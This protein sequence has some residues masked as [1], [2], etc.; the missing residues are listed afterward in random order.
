[1][2]PDRYHRQTILPEVGDSGRSRLASAHAVVVGCGALGCVSADLLA[3][4]GVGRLTIID[5]DVVELTNLQRQTLFDEADARAGLPKAEAARR[6]LASVNASIGVRAVVADVSW[7]SI[8]ALLDGGGGDGPTP[9]VILDGTDNFEAR[10]LL[11]DYAVSR[12]VPFV[13]AGAVATEGLTMTILP[14]RTPCLRCV[15]EEPPAPGGAAVARTCELA[16]VFAPASSAIAAL[17]AG[18][19]LKVLMGRA[20]AVAPGLLSIDAW[21]GAVRRVGAATGPRGDCPCCARREFP[22]LDGARGDT[23]AALC[24]R[25]A[26][27]IAPERAPASPLDLPAL[28]RRLAPHGVF[29]ATPFLVR[30]ELDADEGA[31][32]LT[33]FPDARAIIGTTSEPRARAI[34]ARFVGA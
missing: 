13:Y 4:A 33:V 6:R 2:P 24:G 34:Y 12:G 14:G 1:M 3:R 8:A 26:V 11:N 10:Y 18:E 25:T 27:Q 5:R 29:E 7:R 19:A 30:G 23:R 9:G 32:P 15:F 20:D 21:R 16:G 17:Q 22:F 28:A 31:V